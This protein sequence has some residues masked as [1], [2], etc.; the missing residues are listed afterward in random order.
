MTLKPPACLFFCWFTV[1]LLFS[2][3]SWLFSVVFFPVAPV[4]VAPP[5]E[6]APSLLLRVN[7]TRVCVCVYWTVLLVS[8]DD[9]VLLWTLLVIMIMILIIRTLWIYSKWSAKYYCNIECINMLSSCLP[10]VRRVR[11]ASCLSVCLHCHISHQK[12]QRQHHVIIS[13]HQVYNV[14]YK[15]PEMMHISLLSGLSGWSGIRPVHTASLL[16]N[17]M[18]TLLVC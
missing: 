18:H 15:P 1:V 11:Q 13:S 12:Q 14:L 3:S 4:K 16:V 9:D 2:L 10:A 8:T 7:L 6:R 17:C 5:M